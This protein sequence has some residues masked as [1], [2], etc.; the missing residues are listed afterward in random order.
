MR[1]QA[2]S[3]AGA[4][5]LMQIMPAT[6]RRLTDGSG[7][8]D[9]IREQLFD[10][11][12]NVRLGSRYMGQLLDRFSG[13][14]LY[15]VASYNAGPVAV[16]RW[17]RTNGSAEPEKFVE[18]IPYRETRGYVKRVLRSYREYHRLEN[19]GCRAPSLD[20]AC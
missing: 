20:K 1:S 9:E 15:A 2:L 4:V 8:L 18:L 10:S 6:A 5:G 12:T 16:S 13:N 14:V 7:D 17:I 19:G 11:D 3:P